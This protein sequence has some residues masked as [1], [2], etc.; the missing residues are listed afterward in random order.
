MFKR[1]AKKW[2]Q[3][4]AGGDQVGFSHSQLL[5]ALAAVASK[6]LSLKIELTLTRN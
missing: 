5:V 4:E 2:V 1:P 6:M 3:D